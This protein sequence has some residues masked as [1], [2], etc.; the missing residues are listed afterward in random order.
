MKK[1]AILLVFIFLNSISIYGQRSNRFVELGGTGSQLV[2]EGGVN[3][4]DKTSE[5]N[6]AIS[7]NGIKNIKLNGNMTLG[8][9]DLASNVHIDIK[10]GVVI[11]LKSSSN[12]I[13]VASRD[14]GDLAL[15]NIKIQCSECS[16]DFNDNDNPSERY[17]IDLTVKEPNQN[18]IAF[19]LAKIKNFSI[20]HFYVIDNYTKINSV[21]LTPVIRDDTGGSGPL[22]ERDLVVE[23]VPEDGDIKYGHIVNGHIGYGLIQVQAA[24]NI[25]FHYLSGIGGVTLRLE[26]GAAI[27]N[28]PTTEQPIAN[29]DLLEGY[30]VHC[31]NGWS[32]VT[33]SPHGRR[34][35][36]VS[37]E[38]IGAKS[39]SSAIRIVNG[40]Q[41]KD[42]ED[43][44]DFP[45]AEF[46]RGN[47]GSVQIS[48]VISHELGNDAQ[49]EKRD[50]NF[51]PESFRDGKTFEEKFPIAPV[52]PNNYPPFDPN[53]PNH[54]P[55]YEEGIYKARSIA[56]VIFYA[57]DNATAVIDEVEG[58]YDADF[59]YVTQYNSPGFNSCINNILYR[60]DRNN[61]CLGIILSANEEPSNLLNGNLFFN[62]KNE[63]IDFDVKE[64]TELQVMS[65]LGEKVIYEKASKGFNS[66]DASSLSA[67]VYLIRL[68][69]GNNVIHIK[70][71]V[72]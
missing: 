28:V 41:D 2:I 20:S 9:I 25:N 63:S 48:G 38:N 55:I 68:K 27:A 44:V 13:F 52:D 65:L 56:L 64:N 15:E 39:C 53:N 43:I 21:V 26:S 22:Y 62:K 57:K 60:D 8:G 46:K 72:Y 10:K 70:Q 59:T 61:V 50:Y 35:N 66:V 67:G 47:F 29:M 54:N 37:L 4:P 33:L 18:A 51:Y 49:M 3:F 16:N 5:L 24:K 23:G 19:A 17:T 31:E 36:S 58:Q 1:I 69:Q 71:Y 45:N 42:L 7:I 6:T 32:A 11:K 14:A 12:F 30:E 34:H 40:F